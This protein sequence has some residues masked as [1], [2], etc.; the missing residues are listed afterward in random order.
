VFQAYEKM[1]YGL[2][3]QASRVLTVGDKVTNP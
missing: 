3:L 1:S 2:V